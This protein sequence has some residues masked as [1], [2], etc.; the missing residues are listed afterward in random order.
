MTI[1]DLNG[2][3]Q[4]W[5]IKGTSVGRNHASHLHCSARELLHTLMPTA[6]LKEEVPLP[7]R[8][9]E[10][11]YFDFYIPLYK[12]AIEIHGEQHF[13]FVRLFHQTREG[14]LLSKKNDK[15]KI[16]WCNANLISLI[17]LPYNEDI[18]EW[19]ERIQRWRRGENGESNSSS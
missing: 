11:L 12:L 10:T 2:H 4:Q 17:T 9:G 3:L 15:N 7:L 8:R 16:A 6:L 1:I 18:N 5:A 19:T 14:F 13:K